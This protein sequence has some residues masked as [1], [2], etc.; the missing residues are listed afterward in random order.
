MLI[1]VQRRSTY[2]LAGGENSEWIASN[3]AATEAGGHLVTLTTGAEASFVTNT[4]QVGFWI[5]LTDA[6]QEGR[7][8]WVTGESFRYSNWAVGQPDDRSGRNGGSEDYAHTLSIAERNG[9]WNDKQNDEFVFT[10]GYVIEWDSSG[11]FRADANPYAGRSSVFQGSNAPDRI[12]AG[13]GRDTLFGGV[14]EDALLGNG[15]DDW[16][17]GGGGFDRLTGGN[18]ADTFVFL[19]TDGFQSDG[20]RDFSRAEGDVVRIEGYG[21]ADADAVMAAATEIGSGVILTLSPLASVFI[22]GANFATFGAEDIVV[23]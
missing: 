2:V 16:L 18:G 11:A 19:G 3:L 9:A 5:G 13:A 6:A 22:I 21:F 17:Y 10:S 14:G 12:A 1:A 4:F 23:G 20:I 15:G 7:F 8:E